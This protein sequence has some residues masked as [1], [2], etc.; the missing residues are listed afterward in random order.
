[1]CLLLGLHVTNSDGIC[2]KE[3]ML[4]AIASDRY[5]GKCRVEDRSIELSVISVRDNM[6]CPLDPILVLVQ[7][8]VH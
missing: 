8:H 1:M 7:L 2:S 5:N 6:H 3:Y 4:Q